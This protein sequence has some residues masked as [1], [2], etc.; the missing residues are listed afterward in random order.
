MIMPRVYSDD[1]LWP[2]R[3]I[4]LL[5]IFFLN[6]SFLSYESMAYVLH[7][8]KP[9][10]QALAH[11]SRTFISRPSPFQIL[12]RVLGGIFLCFSPKFDSIFCKQTMK[13]LIRHIAFSRCFLQWR[14]FFI[15]RNHPYP[16]KNHKKY[17]VS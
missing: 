10:P 15:A 13:P 4:H 11:L 3:V 8:E 9:S 17:R 1:H 5:F 14:M 16:L 7:R 2:F 6:V 12:G